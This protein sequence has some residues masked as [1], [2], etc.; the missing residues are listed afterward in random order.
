ME[1]SLWVPLHSSLLNALDP[2][3]VRS[4]ATTGAG[5]GL[6]LL[7]PYIPQDQLRKAVAEIKQNRP[8]WLGD[9]YPLAGF[10][11]QDRDW[12]VWQFHRSDLHAGYALFFR[13]P[14]SLQSD[15][16]VSLRGLDP[17]AKYEVT[18]AETYDVKDRRTM[19][20]NDLSKLRVNLPSPASSMLVRYR[21][22]EEAR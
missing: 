22:I 3:R 15:M 17:A 4:V 6:N 20:G 9:F 8:Y 10:N 14:K 21:R 5:I 19:T 12:C 2:Y 7:S 18:F 11:A 16:T 13:R 1:L